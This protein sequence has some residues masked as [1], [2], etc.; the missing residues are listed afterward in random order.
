MNGLKL[1]GKMNKIIEK[2]SFIFVCFLALIGM[3]VSGTTFH[4]YSHYFDYKPINKTSDEL[5]VLNLP[6]SLSM[7]L[8]SSAGYYKFSADESEKQKVD[9]ISKYTELK[10]YMIDGF[11]IFI[12]TFAMI[13]VIKNRGKNDL[14]NK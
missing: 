5:C 7:H 12:S 11:F 4:E 1:R 6:T 9:K 10:A 13:I 2:I 8:N 3:I 14:P